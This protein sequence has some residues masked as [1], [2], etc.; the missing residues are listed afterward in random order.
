MLKRLSIIGYIAMI[1]GFLGL[2]AMGA[3]LSPAPAV[4]AVQLVAVL[5]FLWARIILGLRSYHVAADPTKGCLVTSGPYRWI[6]HPIYT[7]FCVFTLAGAAAHW[8]WLSGLCGGLVVGSALTR[9]FCEE[10]LLAARYPEYRQYAAR[11]WRM[12]PYVY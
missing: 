3:L 8:S 2:L 1:G 9:I 5:L 12:I 6:R 11:T 7:A 4:I 10:T